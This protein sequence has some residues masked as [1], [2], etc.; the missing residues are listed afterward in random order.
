MGS[1]EF[2][3]FVQSWSRD[4]SSGGK[5]YTVIVN[6]PQSILNSSYIIL[7]QYVGSI[8]SKNSASLFGGP[9][10]YLY[11]TGIDAATSPNNVDLS[12]GSIANVFNVYGFLESSGPYGFGGSRKNSSASLAGISINDVLRSLMILTSTTKDST[13][14][15]G[16]DVG[17]QS[18]RARKSVFSPFGRIISK[19]AQRE[20]IKNPTLLYTQ[21]TI[22]TFGMIPPANLLHLPVASALPRCNF[23][24]DLHDVLYTDNTR[25]KLRMSDS[26]KINN[27]SMSIMELLNEVSEKIGCDFSYELK[28]I[29]H[30]GVAYNVIKVNVISRLKQPAPNIIENTIKDLECNN[31]AITSHSIGKEKNNTA[32][33][34]LTIGAPQQRLLQV[35]SYRLAYSQSNFIFNPNIRFFNTVFKIFMI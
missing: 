33:R 18:D 1:F 11:S 17:G 2:G 35:K 7:D 23:V 10:N 29:T 19:S 30:S 6:G 21:S 28:I 12:K 27:T 15:L 16:V 5:Q 4:M 14:K 13:N 32:A 22:D 34:S 8:F 26:I 3:G 24:L 9:K 25:S 20:D 31:Y